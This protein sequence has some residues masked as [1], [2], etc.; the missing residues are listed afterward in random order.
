MRAYRSS[1]PDGPLIIQM[2]SDALTGVSGTPRTK[3]GGDF[4]NEIQLRGTGRRGR[5]RGLA[6]AKTF[7][8]K[9][10]PSELRKLPRWSFAEALVS[11]A[12]K[13]G[14]Q[15]DLRAAERQLRQ[16][17]ANEGWLADAPAPQ[18][19]SGKGL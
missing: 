17:L 10:V 6:D 2:L 18:R 5:V 15:R 1:E 7:I 4:Q 8:L 14:K 9:E 11:H 19:K 3:M 13:T 16:A 12:K